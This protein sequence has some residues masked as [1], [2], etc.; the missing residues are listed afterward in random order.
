MTGGIHLRNRNVLCLLLAASLATAASAQQFGQSA[1]QEANRL[2]SA[3]YQR[4]D[5]PTAIAQV[6][7][8]IKLEPRE[9]THPYNLAC[10]L[11]LNGKPEEAAKWARKSAEM[12]FDD[13]RLYQTDP[14]LAS[15]RKQADYLAGLEL[16]KRQAAGALDAFKKKAAGSKPLVIVPAGLDTSKPAPLIVVLSGFGGTAEGI[17][18]IWK[19]AA[20]EAGAIL[21]APRAVH[22]VAGRGFQWGTPDEADYLVTRAIEQVKG[23]HKIDPKRIVLAGFSQGGF[24]AYVLGM[25]HALEYRG[26]IPVAGQYNASQAGPPTLTVIDLPRFFIM[27]GARDNLVQSNRQAAKDYESVG[28]KVKL[29]VYPGVGHAFP[30]DR[31]AELR[32]ALKYVLG[33]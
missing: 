29:N 16:V 11:A 9:S 25:R 4:K 3:A 17:A 24:M 21:V 22:V 1:A 31:E 2:M 33:D 14:D 6:K 7:K 30:N 5:Y 27:V 12:G 10:F 26:V 32:K 19:S 23:K 8:L 13:A 15:I 28:M 18:K 20:G